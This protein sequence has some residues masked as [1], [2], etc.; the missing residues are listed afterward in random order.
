M[1]TNTDV[2]EYINVCGNEEE[3]RRL[4]RYVIARLKQVRSLQAM[5]VKG[6]LREGSRVSFPGGI[7]QGRG[8]KR[9]QTTLT[10]TVTD[11]KQKYAIV[12][13]DSCSVWDSFSNC[14]LRVP[15]SS[16]TLQGE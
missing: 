8:R 1:T 3:L 16:I 5:S 10:G 14:S 11:V 6:Q 2:L 12:Q 7:P 4:N 13:T 15:M 9:W